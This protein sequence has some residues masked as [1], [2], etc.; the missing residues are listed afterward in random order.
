MGEFSDED[1]NRALLHVYKKNQQEQQKQKSKTDEE[2]RK[3]AHKEAEEYF[4]ARKVA[5]P[6]N[7]KSIF[8]IKPTMALEEKLIEQYVR[9]PLADPRQYTVVMEGKPFVALISMDNGLQYRAAITRLM[10]IEWPEGVKE[11]WK[12]LSIK[13]LQDRQIEKPTIHADKMEY[14]LF[15]WPVHKDGKIDE[16]D[17][18]DVRWNMQ[19]DIAILQEKEG[20]D[21]GDGITTVGCV[22]LSGTGVCT[23]SFQLLNH[24]Y[25]GMR[26]KYP[27]HFHRLFSEI[28]KAYDRARVQGTLGKAIYTLLDPSKPPRGKGCTIPILPTDRRI[29]FDIPEI[30]VVNPNQPL[31]LIH[32]PSK[33]LPK[34]IQIDKPYE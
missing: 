19:D 17:N 12:P 16:N 30:K 1:I 18:I 5:E 32:H 23:G 8:R 34:R 21:S 33:P 7:V 24:P 14:A 6:A 4:F 15:L 20:K 27:R 25:W 28:Q 13:L 3:R 22:H 9:F 29:W 11:N 26:E 31:R 10:Y 2:R